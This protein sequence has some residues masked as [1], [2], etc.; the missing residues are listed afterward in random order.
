MTGLARAQRSAIAK[1]HRIAIVDPSLPAADIGE[2]SSHR[3]IRTFFEELR[4]LGYVEDQNL[5]I[6]RFSGEGRAVDTQTTYYPG[7]ARDV[8]HRNPDA[9]FAINN[10]VVLDFKAATTTI[11]IVAVV[12]DPIAFGIVP[13]LARPGGNITGIS[14]VLD[15]STWSRRV[16]LLRETAPKISK[17]G[18]LASHYAWNSPM[19][20]VVRET[21]RK[22]GVSLIG[23]PLDAPYQ[24]AEYRRVLALMEQDGAEALVVGDLPDTSRTAV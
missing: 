24:E 4:L 15:V 9:I 10:Q 20:A 21:A 2:K 8:V 16:E 6:E 5:L 11:P 1:V 3:G 17:M 14:P 19:G 22:V 23:P 7:L 18:F 12:G 13:S